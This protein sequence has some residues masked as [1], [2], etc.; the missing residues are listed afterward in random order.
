[1]GLFSLLDMIYFLIIILFSV[2]AFSNYIY[3]PFIKKN[4]TQEKIRKNS[5]EL[6]ILCLFSLVS[7]V[8]LISYNFDK[9][10]TNYTSKNSYY[11]MLCF[12]FIVLIGSFVLSIKT[13]KIKSSSF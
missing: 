2:F 13:K 7:L 4:I 10:L 5:F 12:N 3:I 11:F 9:D 1:M 6:T 8:M